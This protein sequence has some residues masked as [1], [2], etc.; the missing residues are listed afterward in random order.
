MPW[1]KVDPMDQR[2]RF[3]FEATQKNRNMTELCVRYGISRKTGYKWL[4]RYDAEG[5]DGVYDK[6]RAPTKVARKTPPELEKLLLIEKAQHPSWGPKKLVAH[7]RDE[8]GV[9]PPAASTAGEILKRHGL[10]KKRRRRSKAPLAWPGKLT[11]PERANHVWAAD[12]KGWFRTRDGR[13][14]FPLTVSD[15]HSRYLLCVDALPGHTHEL[16]LASFERVFA[17]YGL[18]EVIRVDN[19]SPFA[20]RGVGN[21]SRLSVIWLRLGIRVEFIEPGRPD[22][23]GRHER[24]HRTLKAETARPPKRN[25][26]EQQA[27]F[28]EWREEFN[29]VRPHES[30]GQKPPATRYEVSENVCPDRLPDFEYPRHFDRRR[31]KGS[32]EIKWGRTRIFI[33]TGY[34]GTELGVDST[35]PAGAAVYV[36]GILLGTIEKC[37]RGAPLSHKLVRVV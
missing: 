32:G 34:V 22:Q 26:A 23:N 21:L 12:Y 24:M 37:E 31:V 8:F 10:V 30:L 3:V 15:L 5:V 36:G 29:E 25:C 4:N 11:L 17:D 33:G 9:T 6:S 7:I 16:T 35:H 18:P 27:R 2:F 19:G 1:Q 14:C 28:D 13:K 20:G